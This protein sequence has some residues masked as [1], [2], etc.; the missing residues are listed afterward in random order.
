MWIRTSKNN[1]ACRTVDRRRRSC[2]EFIEGRPS[3]PL[4][5]KDVGTV[6]FGGLAPVDNH[7]REPTVGVSKVIVMLAAQCNPLEWRLRRSRTDTRTPRREEAL[8]QQWSRH[9]R[10]RQ[11]SASTAR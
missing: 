8:R 9:C 5:E 1:S 4:P 2:N 6:G 7:H 10:L 3:D 11:K